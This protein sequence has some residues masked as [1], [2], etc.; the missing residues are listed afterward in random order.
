MEIMVYAK[1]RRGKQYIGVFDDLSNLSDEVFRELETA[2]SLNLCKS[3]YFLL[4]CE[5]FKLFLEGE[6]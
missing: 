4:N 5:E 2:E 3:T 6:K 1:T